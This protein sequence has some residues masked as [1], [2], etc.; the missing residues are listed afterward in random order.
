[1]ASKL[2]LEFEGTSGEVK[3]NYNYANPSAST[4]N[5]KALVN[6]II[7]NGSIFEN[8]PTKAVSAKIVTTTEDIIDITD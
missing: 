8:P 6:G 5:I 1:M 3:F 2:V 7:T 4:A